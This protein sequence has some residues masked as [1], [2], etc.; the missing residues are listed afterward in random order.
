MKVLYVR[1][2]PDLREGD[3]P[4]RTHIM[5]IKWSV[6]E[7]AARECEIVVA[8][9]LDKGPDMYV[10]YAAWELVHVYQQR[11]VNGH[12]HCGL[13]LGEPVEFHG[14]P[15]PAKGRGGVLIG[16]V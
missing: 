16:R 13:A 4:Y 6:S 2:N 9:R 11:R 8:C 10:P 14:G 1:V 7:R 3:K 15:I 12:P 5:E